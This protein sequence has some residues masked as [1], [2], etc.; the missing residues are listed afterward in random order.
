MFCDHFVGMA[1]RVSPRS[2][3][4]AAS[5]SSASRADAPYTS[6]PSSDLA[7]GQAV[8]DRHLPGGWLHRRRTHIDAL[9]VAEPGPD[10]RIV[11]RIEF[12]LPG[13]L[14]R[15][16][17]A[18]LAFLT[19]PSP[20]IRLSNNVRGV[21]GR[22]TADRDCEAFRADGWRSASRR[23]TAGL[24]VALIS[25]HLLGNLRGKRALFLAAVQ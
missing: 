23:C 9:L 5:A 6:G 3:N 22:A 18:A 24:A 20:C 17:C 16:A 10:L 14:N 8:L 19:R 4:S 25:K 1:A 13:I 15:D 21:L 12:Y 7:Q 2:A 11:G